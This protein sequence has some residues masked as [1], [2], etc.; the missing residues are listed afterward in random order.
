M[1]I[2]QFQSYCLA[3][4]GVTEEFP[5]GEE[6]LVYKVM[7]KMFALADVTLFESIN[8]K[9]DPEQ[10]VALREQYPAVLPGYHMNKKHWNTV[11]MDGSLPDK[12][13]KSWIDDSYNLVVASLPVKV[14]AAL[15]AL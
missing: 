9:C 4:P 15:K 11:Q 3:K 7:G 14:R 10:A 5:F 8:L 12:L 1:N 2:E 6:T 13:V